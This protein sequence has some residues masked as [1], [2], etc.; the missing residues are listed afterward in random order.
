MS[1]SSLYNQRNGEWIGHI[2]EM[3]EEISMLE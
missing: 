3:N 2:K 1:I